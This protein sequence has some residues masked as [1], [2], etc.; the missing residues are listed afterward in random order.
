MPDLRNRRQLE[1]ELIEELAIADVETRREIAAL[2]GEEIAR[3][4][5]APQEWEAIGERY[6]G[7]IEQRLERVYMASVVGLALL[8][9][10]ETPQQAVRLGDDI[11]SRAAAWSRDH[12]AQLVRDLNNTSRRRI[13]DEIVR[14]YNND[15]TRQELI[16]RIDTVVY[17]PQ[18]ARLIAETEITRANTQAERDALESAGLQNAFTGVWVTARD[19]RTCPICRPLEGTTKDNWP[20]YPPAHPGCR[21]FIDWR[22]NNAT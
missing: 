8:L 7:I 21:C 12:S 4:G 20:T 19:D 1:R 18:R 2:L 9:T 17:N 10:R 16:N 11:A 3:D 5:L 13:Q 14:Y 22:P 6:R 15:I